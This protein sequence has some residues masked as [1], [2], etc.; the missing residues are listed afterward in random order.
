M[1]GECQP[2]FRHVIRQ[3]LLCVAKMIWLDRESGEEEGEQ[4]NERDDG[5]EDDVNEDGDDDGDEDE[6]QSARSDSEESDD[7]ILAGLTQCNLSC[8]YVQ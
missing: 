1:A 5:E 4:D 8:H 3:S 6:E 7:G 2:L